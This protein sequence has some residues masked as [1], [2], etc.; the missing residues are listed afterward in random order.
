MLCQLK[1]CRFAA[2]LSHGEDWASEYW[3]LLWCITDGFPIVEG[4]VPSY[5]C[6]NY[7]SIL[8]DGC[9]QKMDKIITREL[10]EGI[11][12]EAV[13]WPNC[14]HALGAVPKQDGGIRPITDCSRPSGESVNNYCGSLFKEFN[15]KSVDDVVKLLTWGNFMSVIDIKSA[16]RAVPI[17]EEHRKY[18]GFQWEL[19]G[20]LKTFVDNRM[21]F[22]LRL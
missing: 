3:E 8:E 13:S 10:K 22:G 16:Y 2:I 17:R 9:K 19:D 21:C 6:M 5:H 4:D 20:V 7:N 14:I 1:P 18:M 11:I 12:S 15:Y